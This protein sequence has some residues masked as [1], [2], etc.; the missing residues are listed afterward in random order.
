M[1]DFY[2]PNPHIVND[3]LSCH[4]IYMPRQPEAILKENVLRDLKALPNTYAVKIQQLSIRGTPD[5]FACVNGYFIALELKRDPS[6]K[7]DPLQEY[8]LEKISEAG[9]MSYVV[10]PTNWPSV[11][12]TLTKLANFHQPR[13]L[14]NGEDS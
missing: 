6:Q 4:S 3:L 7:P 9:G 10:N 14:P 11:L 1:I 5:I 12:T 8:E 13:F 2:G